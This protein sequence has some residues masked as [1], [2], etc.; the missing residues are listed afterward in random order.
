MVAEEGFGLPVEA[1][2][3]AGLGGPLKA[4]AARDVSAMTEG[5]DGGIP[6]CFFGALD[7]SLGDR[8][9]PA[10]GCAD[11]LAGPFRVSREA[12]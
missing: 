3:G 12:V 4:V 6:F 11:C 5:D 9:P 1:A 7:L 2:A 8:L 10:V